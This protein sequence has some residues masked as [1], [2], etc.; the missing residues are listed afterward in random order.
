[1]KIIIR[2]MQKPTPTRFG[3]LMM[4]DIPARYLLLP[5]SSQRFMA[6]KTRFFGLFL[7]T[8]F[9]INEHITGLKV[10]ATTVERSTEM[11]I[12]TLN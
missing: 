1:M 5:K 4:P 3:F 10:R 8:G 9:S 2:T 11:T 6:R 12:V 7:S